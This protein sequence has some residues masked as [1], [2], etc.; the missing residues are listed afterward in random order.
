V[1]VLNPGERVEVQDPNRS[2]SLVYV[3]GRAVGYLSV[4]LLVA[5]PPGT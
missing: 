3:G 1:R 4:A 2:W 5:E